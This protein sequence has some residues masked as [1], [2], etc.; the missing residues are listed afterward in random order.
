MPIVWRQDDGVGGFED[1]LGVPHGGFASINYA[2]G[3]LSFN[4]TVIGQFPLASYEPI[5]IGTE[6]VV[7]LLVAGVDTTGLDADETVDVYRNQLKAI[8]YVNTPSFFPPANSWVKVRYATSDSATSRTETIVW[9]TLEIDMTPDYNEQVVAG[10]L[11]LSF[12]GKTILDRLGTIVQDL[13]HSNGAA[14]AVGTIDYGSGT[15]VLDSWTPG[16]ANG[17]TVQALLTNVAG[18]PV[19]TIAFRVPAVP[20]RP[21]SFIMQFV[22]LG[23]QGINTV[24]AEASGE[25]SGANVYGN[26]DYQTGIVR[27]RFGSWVTEAVYVALFW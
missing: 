21:S 23:E 19:D 24:S 11:R 14:T 26:I 8:E 13:N 3:A 6:G 9:D 18:H 20:I 12:G 16:V 10:S 27:I 1:A 2:T 4:P 17:G 5:K 25:I 22:I 15:L 7:D